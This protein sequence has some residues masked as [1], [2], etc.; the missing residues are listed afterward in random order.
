MKSDSLIHNRK[1]IRLRGFDYSTSGLYFI[2][3]C[4][5][6]HEAFFGIVQDDKMLFNDI[7]HI[8]I[9]C[10]EGLPKHFNKVSLDEFVL[11]PNHFH[12]IINISGTEGII[13]HN[14]LIN[15][16]PTRGL[17]SNAGAINQAPTG[18]KNEFVG[19]QFI[20]PEKYNATDQG[21]IN[22]APTLGMIVRS[23]KSLSSRKIHL[24]GKYEFGWQR[25]YYEHIIRN[26]DSLNYIR[27]YIINNPLRWELDRENPNR[28]GE[29]EFDKWLV[30]AQIM[31]LQGI[32]TN[33]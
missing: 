15:Q 24:S 10:W 4:T 14:G 33:S 18:D 31:P 32:K 17:M 19:A 29:D 28:K 22:Q 16:A 3:I 25:N 21:L 2:T 11:M 8:V 5:R 1:N 6:N 13:K 9:D 26:E 7:S 23:F 30:G 12:G 20:A 27:E